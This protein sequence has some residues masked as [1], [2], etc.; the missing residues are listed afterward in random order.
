[1]VST[2]PLQT[3]YTVWLPTVVM[4]H[5]AEQLS[6]QPDL[7]AQTGLQSACSGTSP[8]RLHKICTAAL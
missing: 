1:M 8:K 5:P 3:V 7:K 2:A 6:G 4:L